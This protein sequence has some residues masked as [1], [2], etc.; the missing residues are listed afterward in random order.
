MKRSGLGDRCPGI[1]ESCLCRYITSDRNIMLAIHR[2]EDNKSI[3]YATLLL[4]S[5]TSPLRSQ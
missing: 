1:S 5:F 2:S 4:D 3:K